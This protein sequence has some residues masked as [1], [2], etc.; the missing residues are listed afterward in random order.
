M[1]LALLAWSFVSARPQ[2][3]EVPMVGSERVAVVAVVRTA[4][5]GS[6]EAAA[7]RVLSEA[8]VQGTREFTRRELASYGSQTGHPIRVESLPDHLAIRVL[9]PRA[10][11]LDSA[12]PLVASLLQNPILDEQSVLAAAKRLAEDE[13]VWRTVLDPVE[14]PF[15]KVTPRLV[16][17]VALRF[18]RPENTTIAIAGGFERGQGTEAVEAALRDW[19]PGRAQIYDAGGPTRPLVHRR[20]QAA[21]VEFSVD[22]LGPGAPS[23]SHAVRIL[24]AFALGVGKG[25][26]LHRIV[27]ERLGRSYRQEAVLWPTARGWQVRLLIALGSD[28]KSEEAAE[29]RQVLESDVRE[30]GE[31]DLQ[32]ARSLA[33]R[34]LTFGLEVSP[35]WWSS[36]GPEAVDEVGRASWAAIAEMAG[37]PQATR[38][39]VLAAF[40]G[41]TLEQ[42]RADAASVLESARVCFVQGAQA[43]GD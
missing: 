4:P 7:L 2:V 30:W 29:I 42:L 27:R 31:T 14:L 11:G 38:E 41:V 8:M 26:S 1:M 32:R 6:W 5:R 23:A 3:V 36:S 22:P 34:A 35:I 28:A 15:E 39:A 43:E 18:V 16:R 19:R 40:P 20:G 13:D 10:G 25:G 21:S 33:E 9:A 24:T 37:V 12:M 17:N